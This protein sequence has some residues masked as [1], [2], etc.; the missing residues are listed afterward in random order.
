MRFAAQTDNDI[1]Q[2]AVIHIDNAFPD[3]PARIDIQYVAL[4]HMI[5][6]HGGEQHMRGS[7]GMEIT[8]KMQ[9]D[10]LHRHYLRITAAGSAA[11]DAHA[12][13]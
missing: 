11:F 3:D 10:I 2:L 4:L 12:G 13:S 6:H 8:C 5:I 1:T 9:V 7:N